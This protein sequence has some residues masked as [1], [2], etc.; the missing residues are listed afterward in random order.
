MSCSHCFWDVLERWGYLPSPWYQGRHKPS[1]ASVFSS[2]RVSSV[3]YGERLFWHKWRRRQRGQ[4]NLMPLMLT[5]LACCEQRAKGSADSL[6]R[7]EETRLGQTHP[8]INSPSLVFSQGIQQYFAAIF[9]PPL[10]A[11]SQGRLRG[12]ITDTGWRSGSNEW[13][14]WVHKEEQQT[15]FHSPVFLYFYLSC[16]FRLFSFNNNHISNQHEEQDAFI[17]RSYCVRPHLSWF[18][19]WG[20]KKTWDFSKLHFVLRKKYAFWHFQ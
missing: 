16:F 11:V 13:L 1:E 9:L 3:E 6:S 7:L 5:R 4:L 18:C 20:K 2:Y 17:F 10:M 8:S 19:P 15:H 14:G 12:N